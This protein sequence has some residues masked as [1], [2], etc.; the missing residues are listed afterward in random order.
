MRIII[1][2][3]AP[4]WLAR[5]FKTIEDLFRQPMSAP[6]RLVSY[7]VSELPDP[8]SWTGG[9]VFV[10]NEAGGATVAFSDG[11]SWRRAQDRAIVS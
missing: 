7:S 5:A 1:P 2:A 8:A 4:T 9:L 10:P 11:A 6:F 3:Q